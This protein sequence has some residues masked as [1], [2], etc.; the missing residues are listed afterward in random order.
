MSKSTGTNIGA[1]L[2]L[3]AFGT[4]MLAPV[5][6]DFDYSIIPAET[7]AYQELT[8]N[9]WEGDIQITSNQIDPKISSLK[10]FS[11][12]LLKNTSD[13]DPEIMEIVNENYWDLL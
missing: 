8:L 13:M 9:S 3:A 6:Y 5:Q 4:A 10:S 11:E 2:M 12:N 7:V 1:N